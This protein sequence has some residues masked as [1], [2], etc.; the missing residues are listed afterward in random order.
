MDHDDV[1]KQIEAGVP[2][3]AQARFGMN[4][5]SYHPGLIGGMTVTSAMPLSPDQDIAFVRTRMI[6]LWVRGEARVSPMTFTA[7][8]LDHRADQHAAGS[9]PGIAQGVK[10]PAFAARIRAFALDLRGELA[11]EIC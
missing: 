7:G 2:C 4:L 1:R 10:D 11:T 8:Q 6:D 9:G 5:V 3:H